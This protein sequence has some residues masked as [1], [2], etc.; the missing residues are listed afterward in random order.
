MESPFLSV[1]LDFFE[2]RERIGWPFKVPSCPRTLIELGHII[3]VN[4]IP[5]APQAS[6]NGSEAL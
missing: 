3:K 4:P 5:K 2:A 1:N 6:V